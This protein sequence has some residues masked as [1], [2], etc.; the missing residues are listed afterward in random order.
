MSV[1]L[2]DVRRVQARYPLKKR[3]RRAL[4]NRTPTEP[5][6]TL[7]GDAWA[8]LRTLNADTAALGDGLET[9]V[10]QHV[11]EPRARAYL[12]DQW[13]TAAAAREVQDRALREAETPTHTLMQALDTDRSA[14]RAFARELNARAGAEPTVKFLGFGE[15]ST[16]LTLDGTRVAARTDPRT[17]KPIRLVYKR[18]AKFRSRERAEA[19]L[20]LYREYNTI[21]RDGCGLNLPW[22]GDMLLPTEDGQWRMYATQERLPSEWI[23]TGALRALPV[24]GCV[25]LTRRIWQEYTKVWDYDAALPEGALHIGLDGQITNWAIVGFDPAH[26]R[27]AGDEDVLFLDTNMPFMLRNGKPVTDHHIIA[28]RSPGL[29]AKALDPLIDPG[30]AKYHKIRMVMLDY[31]SNCGV[32]HRP[33]VQQALVDL[34]NEMRT[35]ELARFEIDEITYEQVKKYEKNDV[36]T[37]KLLRSMNRVG[38]AIADLSAGKHPHPI[39]MLKDVHHIVTNPIF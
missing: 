32:Q 7:N 14:F 5:V 10:H 20:T 22:F 13:R 27:I 24:D 9:L 12:L 15:I 2:E 34:A 26:P 30:L 23:G 31:I 29:L 16:A 3:L 4:G 37:F 19:A 11:A 6:G 17:H 1:S 8:A 33:D 36:N 28:H 38:Q 35:G 39:Q 18:M 21:L 25:A